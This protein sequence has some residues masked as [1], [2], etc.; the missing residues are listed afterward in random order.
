MLMMGGLV[1]GGIYGSAPNLNMD[2]ANPTLENSN[3]DVKWETDFR[4]VYAKILDNW[5]GSNSAT[6][7][8][9][10]YRAGAPNVL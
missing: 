2:P 8:G 6:I 1:R 5:L 9:A 10:D 4:G 3:G 7:L